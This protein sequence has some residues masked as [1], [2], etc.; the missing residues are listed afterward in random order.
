MS[1]RAFSTEEKRQIISKIQSGVKNG[2]L[3]KEWKTSASMIS[4]I[5]K[6]RDKILN[7]Q[8]VSS[9][10]RLREL[11]NK[12]L[13]NVLYQWFKQQQ[14][15]KIPISS[16]ILQGKANKLATKLGM[17]NFDCSTSWVQRLRARHGIVYGKIVVNFV[18]YNFCPEIFKFKACDPGPST[19]YSQAA[20]SAVIAI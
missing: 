15:L 18:K 13:D 16:P 6:N 5:W 17:I 14:A 7:T 10:R 8:G 2:E 9:V 19:V 3:S 1:R 4:I 11:K 12:N 20:V